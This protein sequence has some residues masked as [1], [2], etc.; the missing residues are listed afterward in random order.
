MPGPFEHTTRRE[1]GKR[2]G[3]VQ[4]PHRFER[5]GAHRAESPVHA[6]AF[7]GEQHGRGALVP[8]LI[9]H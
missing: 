2:R 3:R 8:R 9:H 5:A 7:V 4:P 6:A 1:R